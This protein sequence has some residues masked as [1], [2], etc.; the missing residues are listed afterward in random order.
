MSTCII[1]TQRLPKLNPIYQTNGLMPFFIAPNVVAPKKCGPVDQFDVWTKS[2]DPKSRGAYK[3]IYI[4][5]PNSERHGPSSLHKGGLHVLLGDGAVR[6]L[7]EN[8][9]HTSDPATSLWQHLNS[10]RRGEVISGF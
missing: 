7:S 10:I 9:H 8:M 1:E 6:F 2:L 5:G 3:P 4:A